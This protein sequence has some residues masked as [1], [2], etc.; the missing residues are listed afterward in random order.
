MHAELSLQKVLVDYISAINNQSLVKDVEQATTRSE[1]DYVKHMIDTA[2]NYRE[3]QRN[4]SRPSLM[5]C[6]MRLLRPK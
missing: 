2:N 5:S 1:S 6:A 4:A 3:M